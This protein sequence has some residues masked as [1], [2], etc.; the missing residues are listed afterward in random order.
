VTDILDG[1]VGLMHCN[2]SEGRPPSD[3]L[4]GRVNSGFLR[5]SWVFSGWARVFSGLFRR[6][7]GGLARL[8]STDYPPIA[9]FVR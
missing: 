8:S 6:L 3:A 4:A 5:Y 7:F 2:Q 9:G 1:L